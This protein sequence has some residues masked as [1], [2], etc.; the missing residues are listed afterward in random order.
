MAIIGTYWC[1]QDNAWLRFETDNGAILVKRSVPRA[2]NPSLCSGW[3]TLS[4]P[5]DTPV[6]WTVQDST[7]AQN[8]AQLKTFSFNAGTLFLT[9]WTRS[10]LSHLLVVQRLD[11]SSQ[12]WMPCAFEKPQ[13]RCPFT[14]DMVID[15][16]VSLVSENSLPL[17]PEMQ[18]DKWTLWK[19]NNLNQTGEPPV[20][21]EMLDE[22]AN[23]SIYEEFRTTIPEPDEQ[24]SV[25]SYLA[26]LDRIIYD[27]VDPHRVAIEALAARTDWFQYMDLSPEDTSRVIG[28][29]RDYCL[30]SLQ[31]MRNNLA[32]TFGLLPEPVYTYPPVEGITLVNDSDSDSDF[33]YGQG[34]TEYDFDH[35]AT[36]FIETFTRSD[37]PQLRRAIEESEREAQRSSS[38]SSS[39][40][41]EEQW[42][43]AIEAS[44]REAQRSSSGS[45]SPSEEAQIREVIERSKCEL[46]NTS[47][48]LALI[49]RAVARSMEDYRRWYNLPFF[50][51]E[52]IRGRNGICSK[53][54]THTRNGQRFAEDFNREIQ[55]MSLED[56]IDGINVFL[57][58]P[59]T[60][61]HRHSFA[62]FLLD[63]LSSIPGTQWEGF[64][65]DQRGIYNQDAVARSLNPEPVH[66]VGEGDSI[67][68]LNRL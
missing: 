61:Y 63:N 54:F 19:A 41:E 55:K 59:A 26:T 37:D 7:S 8:E 46:Q 66:V 45:S 57:T 22:S 39:P 43:Q 32:R 11:V 64:Q 16:H 25:D 15:R 33:V 4:L 58:N 36:S 13:W 14:N 47:D 51:G 30:T 6:F 40:S 23:A 18:A 56:A 24:D 49:K 12:T 2:D 5:Q 21:V 29:I 27:R 60:H 68:L 48:P 28:T 44:E 42:I 38:R 34:S 53:L 67:H 52:P 10:R 65:V 17:T 9:D 35:Q 3:D 20:I 31:A 62:S 1:Q 50:G